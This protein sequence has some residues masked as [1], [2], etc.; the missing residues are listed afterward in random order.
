[1]VHLGFNGS[2]FF[3]NYDSDSKKHFLELIKPGTEITLRFPGGSIS[4]FT[5][6]YSVRKGW[7]M[8][9]ASVNRFFDQYENLQPDEDDP[10]GGR[11]KW[12]RKV[13]EQPNYSYLDSLKELQAEVASLG[14][15]LNV[16]WV[17]NIINSSIDEQFNTI[18]WL[19]DNN[20]N[21]HAVELGNEV[22]GKYNFDPAAYIRD[23]LA[24]RTAVHAQYP[25]VKFSI[26]S[27]NFR[28]RK[29]HA[30]W[31]ETLRREL[32]ISEYEFVTI[33]F[34]IVQ[35]EYPTP[36]SKLPK[37]KIAIDY[38]KGNQSLEDASK[39]Y[40]SEIFEGT[41]FFQEITDAADFYRKPLLIT[42]FNSKPSNSFGNFLVNGA[43]IMK[44]LSDVVSPVTVDSICLHNGIA[45]DIYGVITLNQKQDSIR[46]TMTKRIG[47]Y[48]MFFA[49][50]PHVNDGFTKIDA[51]VYN[52]S[53][54][55][56]TITLSELFIND[57]INYEVSGYR[58][59]Y[60]AG[61]YLYS[62][63]GYIGHMNKS[64]TPTYEIGNYTEL[65]LDPTTKTVTLPPNSYGT[66]IMQLSYV[67]GTTPEEPEEPE[68]EVETPTDS[69]D[70]P[71]D[72]VDTNTD[73]GD[74]E[75]DK[76]VAGIRYI[77]KLVKRL[78]KGS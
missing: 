40:V 31:N 37:T 65:Q 75:T 47:W 74:T 15:K 56:K 70:V 12:L 8:T 7:G 67:P 16:I 30:M 62:S 46:E 58:V 5:E 69:T 55:P 61:K 25:N 64:Q 76:P 38:T 18:K 50:Q 43:W 26:V 32:K 63:C 72:N 36:Y 57:Y 51:S 41:R 33:H 66:I 17:S 77:K 68:E 49:L 44:Q 4:R 3:E 20:I 60:V 45:P 2:G 71:T 24:L 28:G 29:D 35:A 9:E 52:L 59:L 54:E 22:Y 13:S 21:L 53:A 23:Y 11:D 73:T 78:F 10:E 1:M 48:S 34:Y 19:I 6:P 42:E 14:G 27:G 39:A